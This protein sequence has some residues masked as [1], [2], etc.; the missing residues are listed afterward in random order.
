[1]KLILKN[2]PNSQFVKNTNF[3]LFSF[4][5]NLIKQKDIN[6]RLEKIKAH[7][8]VHYNEMADSLAKEGATSPY[9]G[10]PNLQR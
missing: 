10:L 2:I 3:I 4:I 8:G 9:S 7:E 6:I 5:W 1:M